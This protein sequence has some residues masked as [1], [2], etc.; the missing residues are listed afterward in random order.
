MNTPSETFP[1]IPPLTGALN[2]RDMGGYPT[3]TGGAT[4]WGC[5][6]RSGTAHALTDADLTWLT[7]RGIRFAYDLRSDGERRQHPNRLQDLVDLNYRFVHHDRITGDIAKSLRAAGT[8][9]EDTRR[10]MLAF[11]RALPFAFKDSYRTLLMHLAD[12]DL[13][14]VF[15][16]SVGKDR[17][18]VAAALILS[19]LEVPRSL[20]LED[21]LLTEQYFERSCD[22]FAAEYQDLFNGVAREVWEPL[23]RADADYLQAMLERLQAEHG[24]VVGYVQSELG[25]TEAQIARIRSNLVA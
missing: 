4:R 7:G 9:A 13:P 21:Y 1:R 8:R 18:G 14:L 10:T 5:L 15:N 25:V 24:S 23:M 2:F 12:G 16:C 19:V 11:Y 17:T 20:I 3:A 22:L 6:Y